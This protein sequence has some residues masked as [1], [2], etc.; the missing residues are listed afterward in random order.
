MNPYET[1]GVDPSANAEVIKAAYRAKAKTLHPDAGGGADD[2]ARLS[3]AFEILSDPKR[4]KAYDET[5][6]IDATNGNNADIMAWEI[7]AM[8][9]E[10]FLMEQVDHTDEDVLARMIVG[11]DNA[12]KVI[13]GNI[14]GASTSVR[15]AEKMLKK[16]KRKKKVAGTDMLA[17]MLD[18]RLRQARGHLGEFEKQ[19][20]HHIRAKELLAEYSYDFTPP[21]AFRNSMGDLLR[22]QANMTNPKAFFGY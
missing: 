7:I 3:Q 8:V 4:R 21:P 20:R 10:N 16:F 5:G 11:I 9:L 18:F 17:K 22:E 19:R 1:L 2:F 6:A 13:D 12:L 15:R 14:S